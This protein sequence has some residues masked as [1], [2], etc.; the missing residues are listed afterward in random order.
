[1]RAALLR[2]ISAGAL[3]CV[4]SF[5][6]G[7]ANSAGAQAKTLIIYS[8][9]NEKLIGPLIEKARKD[10]GLDIKVRY[11]KTSQLAIALLEEGRNSRVDSIFCPRCW[12]FGSSGTK[13]AYC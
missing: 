12:G 7:L 5:G 2:K 6:M 9:R 13:T 4:V 11:G 8:G 10:L 1:M 3:A